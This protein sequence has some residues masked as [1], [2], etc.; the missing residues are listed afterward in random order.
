MVSMAMDVFYNFIALSKELNNTIGKSVIQKNINSRDKLQI[1]CIEI[2]QHD[3]RK[4]V[5]TLTYKN[6]VIATMKFYWQTSENIFFK[7]STMSNKTMTIQQFSEIIFSCMTYAFDKIKIHKLSCE[8][9][10]LDCNHR[11]VYLSQGFHIEGVFK[12]HHNIDG[13]YYDVYRLSC[14]RSTF[15]KYLKS[16]SLKLLKGQK[17]SI[18]VGDTYVEAMS[19]SQDEIIKFSEVSGDVNP[20][21]L[22]SRSAINCGFKTNIVH[23]MLSA[24]LFSKILGTRFPGKGSIYLS[25]ELTFLQPIYANENITIELTILSI[26]GNKYTIKTQIKKQGVV[27]LDGIAQVIKSSQC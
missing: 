11:D 3:E 7:I 14:L 2:D 18:N 13:K 20:I 1:N 24:S 5:F 8:I 15:D 21:H 26:I 16:Q 12:Q 4:D 27:A 19:F 17:C 25:Q 23:G 6:N 10:N 22:D 9:V